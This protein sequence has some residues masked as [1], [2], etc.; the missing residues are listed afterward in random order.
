[1]FGTLAGVAGNS[2]DGVWTDTVSTASGDGTA[3]RQ[4][5]FR[6]DVLAGDVNDSDGV[7]I[8]GDV[9]AVFARNWNSLP[10]APV[11]TVGSAIIT[12]AAWIQPGAAN[13]Q[14]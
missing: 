8:T 5:N 1:M 11:P 7:N 2:L 3:G 6:I 12:T 10:S 13:R 14:N 9:L 4:F